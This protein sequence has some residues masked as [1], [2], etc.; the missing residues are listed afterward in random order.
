MWRWKQLAARLGM[1]LERCSRHI[2]AFAIAFL[3]SEGKSES[4]LMCLLEKV[5][6]ARWADWRRPWQTAWK[7]R[8]FQPSAA[9]VG[10]GGAWGQVPRGVITIERERSGS[11]SPLLGL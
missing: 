6:R 9:G 7:F 8:S 5:K 11:G 3:R 4:T 2:P 10:R 1:L